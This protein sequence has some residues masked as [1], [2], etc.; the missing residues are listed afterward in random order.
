MHLLRLSNTKNIKLLKFDR[1]SCYFWDNN[2]NIACK[3]HASIDSCSSVGH[4]DCQITASL[5]WDSIYSWDI[6]DRLIG[7]N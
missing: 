3:W 2:G 4:A 1:T 7:I 6:E 5:E